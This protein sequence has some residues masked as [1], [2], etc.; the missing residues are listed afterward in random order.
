MIDGIVVIADCFVDDDNAA[1]AAAVLAHACWR[2]QNC[3]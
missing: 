2:I 1:A 3:C